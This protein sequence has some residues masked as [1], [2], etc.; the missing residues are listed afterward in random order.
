MRHNSARMP[1]VVEPR[2]G[3]FDHLADMPNH[4]VAGAL[5]GILAQSLRTAGKSWLFY[6]VSS[7]R[8]TTARPLSKIQTSIR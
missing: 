4:R 3:S 5:A 1:L 6:G 8:S 7:A 2:P